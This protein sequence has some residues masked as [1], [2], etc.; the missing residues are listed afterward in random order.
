MEKGPLIVL[1]FWIMLTISLA[2]CNTQ[3]SG[4]NLQIGIIPEQASIKP[5]GQQLF[6]A[7]I[8][9]SQGQTQTGMVI[10]WSSSKPQVATVSDNGFVAA[11]Q[12]GTTQI[13]VSAGGESATATLEVTASAT[14]PLEVV[15]VVPMEG[16]TVSLSGPC[17]HAV[18]QCEVPQMAAVGATFS[19]PG[20]DVFKS[21]RLFIDDTEVTI[22]SQVTFTGALTG[23]EGS[24]IYSHL[25]ELPIGPHQ[26]TLEAKSQAGQTVT[27]TWSFTI[28]A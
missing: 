7:L 2:A 26:A 5:G 8:M 3:D 27:Y 28:T 24:I 23:D 10:H 12:E 15:A 19:F 4:S 1:F 25:L 22:N 13:A 21:A 14:R 17:P 16:E 18:P 11:V 20:D 9:D 6:S